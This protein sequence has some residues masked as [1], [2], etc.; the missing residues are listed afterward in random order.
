MDPE[1]HDQNRF[2]DI[3]LK[4]M[5]I[6]EY[7]PTSDSSLKIATLC[8]ENSGEPVDLDAQS[9]ITLGTARCPDGSI[10]LSEAIWS[11]LQSKLD[12]PC[13]LALLLV[14]RNDLSRI[15]NHQKL[16][17]SSFDWRQRKLSRVTQ[18]IEEAG[19]D[20]YDVRS[21]NLFRNLFR[22]A[23]PK[24]KLPNSYGR[25]DWKIDEGL[26]EVIRRSQIEIN[27]NEKMYPNETVHVRSFI[28]RDCIRRFADFKFNLQ[29]TNF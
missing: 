15:F 22:D 26:L 25:I 6:A 16:I 24:K 18:I 8:L 17:R 11:H 13:H 28:P 23:T 7:L 3:D 20:L 9:H 4:F 10:Q 21:V 27:F 5:G 12:R 1:S 19:V 29:G 14:Y 2:S